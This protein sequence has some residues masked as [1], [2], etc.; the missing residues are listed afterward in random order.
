MTIGFL[1]D[2]KSECWMF[3]SF[4]NP[5]FRIF[6]MIY[7]RFNNCLESNSSIYKQKYNIAN[8]ERICLLHPA[9]KPFL[10]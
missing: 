5:V 1:D 8:L 9:N 4:S 6:A 7:C 10:M 2:S 3:R